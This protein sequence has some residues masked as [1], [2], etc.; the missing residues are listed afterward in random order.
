MGTMG[1]QEK[2]EAK[3][4]SGHKLKASRETSH[5]ASYYDEESSHYMGGAHNALLQ[6]AQD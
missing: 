5:P 6:Y 2:I 1:A 3:P 4:K